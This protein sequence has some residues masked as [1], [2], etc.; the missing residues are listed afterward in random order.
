MIPGDK[1][2][3]RPESSEPHEQG[4]TGKS[5]NQ[6]WEILTH[7]QEHS[8]TDPHSQEMS[9]H[10][11]VQLGWGA[12]KFTLFSWDMKVKHDR[13]TIHRKEESRETQSYT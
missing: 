3:G 2:D 5:D 1:A 11:D 8:Q 13:G 6:Q 7:P 9:S 4:G 12:W 10:F